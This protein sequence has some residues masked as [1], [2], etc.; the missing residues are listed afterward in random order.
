[1]E[2]YLFSDGT[3]VIR[4]V[5]TKEE[6]QTLIQ[7]SADPVRIRIWI[8]NTCEWV[9]LADFSKRSFKPVSSKKIIAGAETKATVARKLS[10]P[11][12]L[13]KTAIGIAAVI[14][15]FLVYNFTKVSWEK[16]APLNITAERPVN[17]PPVNIDSLIQTIE[18]LRG[19]KL[20]KTTRTN[21]RIRNTWPDLLQLQLNTDR[22]I[23]REGSRY[24]NL[25]LSIDNATG[26]NIDNATVSMV[27]WKNN[28]I[29]SNDTLRFTNIDYAT[30]AKRKIEGIYKGDSISVSFTSIRSKVFNFCYSADKKSNYGNYNDRWFCKE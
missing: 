8:F 25:E 10:I 6:L 18:S 30:P 16:A 28:A 15:I 9:S 7:S 13:K 14:V 5:E 12:W 21:L 20:D 2:K 24:Y 27:V 23:S 26:Y 19:Q 22:D 11:A 3:N 4:E 1:M 17:T 29:I